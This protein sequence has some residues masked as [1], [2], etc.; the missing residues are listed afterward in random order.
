MQNF[1]SWH[2][3]SWVDILGV[4]ILGVDILGRIPYY[5]PH[6]QIASDAYAKQAQKMR[7][8]HYNAIWTLTIHH[9]NTC[10]PSPVQ[11]PPQ[12]V[13]ISWTSSHPSSRRLMIDPSKR[14]TLHFCLLLFLQF[15]LAFSQTSEL[16]YCQPMANW[17]LQRWLFLLNSQ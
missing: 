9:V 7:V 17:Y 3:G 16:Y 1:R 2:F 5:S 14:K 4:D 15:Y 10:K 12:L 13:K 11:T 6:S 8:Y